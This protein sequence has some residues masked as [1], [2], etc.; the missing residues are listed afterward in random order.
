MEPVAQTKESLPQPPPKAEPSSPRGPTFPY[1]N[2]SIRSTNPSRDN[3]AHYSTLSTNWDAQTIKALSDI[4]RMQSPQGSCINLIPRRQH[5]DGS[6]SDLDSGATTPVFNGK[7]H[8][9]SLNNKIHE[10][11][12]PE[13]PYHVFTHKKKKML[14]YLAATAGMFSSLSANIYFP[15]L[16]QISRDI[17]VGL[18]LLS[19]TITVYMVAQAFAP[20]FWGPLSDTQGRRITFIGTFGV[21]IIANLG[22]ALST[23][24]VPLMVLRAMQ[25]AGSAATI[26][27]G[28]YFYSGQGLIGDIA[29]PKERGS[30]TGTNQGIRMF[31]QAIG[32]VFGGIIAQYLGYHAIFWVLFGGGIFALTILVVFLPE[33]LRSIASNGTVCLKGIHRPIYYKFTQSEEHLVER[34]IPTKK[35]LTSSMAFGPFMLLLEKDVFSV[36]FFGSIVYAVWSMVT[37]STTALF[38][39]RFNLSDLQVG[40]VFLPNGIASMLGSYLTGKLSKHD[41]AVMEAQYRAAKDIPDSHPLN[42]K[43]LVD[44][45]FAQARMRSIWWMVLIF[46][47]S[48]AL[49]GF[50]LNFNVIAVPLILQFLISYTA[51]SIFALNSTLV[52]DLFPQAS[53]SA[54]AVNNLLMVDSIAS[55]P[56]FAIWAAVAAVLTPL[57]VIQWRN[58]QRWQIERKDRIAAREARRGDPEKTRT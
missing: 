51:N 39:D 50:S 58:G 2:Q 20:S 11:I 22:L 1:S 57:L 41:W 35:R 31:G 46:I 48:T 27:I 49:Y 19:L 21:Y 5:T 53:A 23:G 13:P 44:F 7:S 12:R 17:N 30:F 52:V 38:Q 14:M 33:T 43:E 47:I 54:A 32:P 26:S 36:I 3:L 37:S 40:L 42:K 16:G 9:E 29:T 34:E 18:P 45:P 56:T 10:K 4:S 15:A 6:P 24:F 25:A 28:R 8:I 55:G